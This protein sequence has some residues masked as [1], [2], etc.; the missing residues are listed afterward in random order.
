MV[1]QQGNNA[2]MV[3]TQHEDAFEMLCFEPLMR[4]VFKDVPFE[5]VNQGKLQ[6][7]QTFRALCLGVFS[8][9]WSSAHII[10]PSILPDPAS[11]PLQKRSGW[12]QEKKK[13]DRL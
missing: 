7:K 3:L 2:F 10:C 12:E 1:K 6:Q 13:R 9:L 8:S 4:V 11:P 5:P